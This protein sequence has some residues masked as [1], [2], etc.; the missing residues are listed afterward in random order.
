[1]K[2]RLL[3]RSSPPVPITGAVNLAVHLCPQKL[4]LNVLPRRLSTQVIINV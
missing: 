3:I 2:N 1:M 4:K